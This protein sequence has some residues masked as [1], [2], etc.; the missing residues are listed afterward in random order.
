MPQRGVRFF[1]AGTLLIGAALVLSAIPLPA[2]AAVPGAPVSVT[3]V[4]GSTDNIV[5]T[6][7]PPTTGNAPTEYTVKAYQSASGTTTWDACSAPASATTCEG[8]D[9]LNIPRTSEGWVEVTAENSSGVGPPAARVQVFAYPGAPTGVTASSAD[10]ALTVGWTAPTT[11]VTPTQYTATAYSQVSGGSVVGTP[12]STSTLSCQVTG[13]TNATTYYIEVI[14]SC[15]ANSE[16]STTTVAYQRDSD[17]STR[18]AGVPR[19]LPSAPTDV[20]LLG[21]DSII[22]VSWSAPSSDG[23]SPITNY[24]AE[25]YSAASGGSPVDTCNPSTV[26]S[27]RC[28]LEGLTN[29]TTYFVQVSAQ[30][31]EGTGP[32]TTRQSAQPGGRATEPRNVEV[33]R[34]DGSLN[35]NWT[36]P[37]SDGGSTITSYTARAFTS[38]LSSATAV[39][40]CTA[41]G[42]SCTINGLVNATIYYVS[43][44]ATTSVGASPPSPRVTVR[45][46]A[47]PS[48]PRDVRAPRGNGFSKVT[49]RAP[50]NLNGS[51]ITSYIARAYRTAQ[52]GDVLISCESK[53]EPGSTST[54]PP[55]TCD[56][57]PLPNGTT[58]YI[59]VIAVTSRFVSEPSSPR[60][61]V[62]T[63]ATPDVPR[64]VTA[65]Q[66]GTDVVVRWMVPV[67]DGG[68]SISRYT[69]TAYDSPTSDSTVGSCTSSGDSCTIRSIAGPPL[70]IDVTATTAVGT[71]T[72][73]SPRVK[74]VLFGSPSEPRDVSTQ[75]D[76]KRVIVS[77]LR[78]IDDGDTP[79]TS[80]TAQITD[81]NERLLGSC[82]VRTPK[83]GL[84]TRMSCSI[85][86]I[87]AKV[88]ASAMV[89]A[90]N[91]TSSTSSESVAV[92]ARSGGVGTPREVQVFAAE[93]SLFVAAKRA[94]TDDSKTAYV[95]TAWSKSDK[96]KVLARCT[97]PAQISQPT[98][99]L[100]GLANYTPVWVEAQAQRLKQISEPTSRIEATPM[101]SVPSAPW[102]VTIAVNGKDAKVR[103][104]APLSD[105]GYPVR[106]YTVTAYSDT[107]PTD[108]TIV[109]RCTPKKDART[110][111]LTGLPTEYI[112]VTVVATNP[113]G[114]S[115]PSLPVGRNVPATAP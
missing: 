63:A 43:V 25:A 11:G 86:G 15:T 4:R 9:P 39:A 32:S 17:P 107:E 18:A 27:M 85:G 48:A 19:G 104:Q 67:S 87:P 3:A 40:S 49:W 64:V 71:S 26:A 35:V 97:S 31:I 30:N 82:F 80:Y 99:Q 88:R 76:G 51:I 70:F 65:T 6:W 89:T 100:K 24:V 74:V 58:Y 56:L 83:G 41:T 73:S 75:R 45:A 96:G 47:A 106:G 10:G 59:D 103:W 20:D 91:S 108:E 57:G 94:L 60:I 29:G 69:A 8:A 7:A 46:S 81:T 95:F 23:G 61:A 12:C 66:V 90:K 92:P 55:L 72:P 50:L 111:T 115:Q 113:V 102:G 38:S 53:P 14:A 114:V 33:F 84:D 54:T 34:G 109:G 22:S 101:A 1:R 98:C 110:C 28:V 13:L 93:R 44:T 105:G 112:S 77:W 79:V 2:H 52:G 36:A 37:I 62:L 42:L 21:G 5:V 78:S 68:Q 16:C